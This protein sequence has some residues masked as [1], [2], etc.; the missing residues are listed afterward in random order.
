MLQLVKSSL[1]QQ[2]DAHVPQS[3]HILYDWTVKC[4]W[5]RQERGDQTIEL[6]R[7]T[8]QKKLEGRFVSIN[9]FRYI[10]SAFLWCGKIQLGIKFYL[11]VS[12]GGMNDRGSTCKFRNARSAFRNLHVDP[13]SFIPPWETNKQNSILILILYQNC[14]ALA[15]KYPFLNTQQGGIQ[16]SRRNNRLIRHDNSFMEKWMSIFF[17]CSS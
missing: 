3:L 13:L 5:D 10:V 9:M 1:W 2:R 4:K 7:V 12:H 6:R 17:L 15:M 8:F 16:N 14:P 11:F